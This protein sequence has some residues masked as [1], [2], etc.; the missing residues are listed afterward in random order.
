MTDTAPS[1]AL[2]QVLDAARGAFPNGDV[3]SMSSQ[4]YDS[5]VEVGLSLATSVCVAQVQQEGYSDPHDIVPTRHCVNV[6]FFMQEA[7]QEIPDHVCVPSV[8]V[9]RLRARLTLEEALET[10]EALG[11]QVFCGD[12]QIKDQGKALYLVEDT[13]VEV[14]VED[15]VKECLDCR[16]IATGTILS[17]GVMLTEDLEMEVDVNNLI[18]FRKDKDGHRRDDGKW[19][20]PSDHPKPRIGLVIEQNNTAVIEVA[21]GGQAGAG[22]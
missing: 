11:F 17:L 14:N 1:S 2:K 8:E 4:A 13:S 3:V 18:K 10:I 19:V 15:I 21:G 16:V 5:V 6:A 12:V 9:R 7:G 22:I 20:K